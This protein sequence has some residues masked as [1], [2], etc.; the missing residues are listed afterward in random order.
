MNR[1]AHAIVGAAISSAVYVGTCK[2]LGRSVNPGT[3]LLA[4]AL[5]GGAACLH[6]V[7]EP[8]IHPNH[9]GF[10]HSVVLTGAA[11][12][13]VRRYWLQPDG[14]PGQRALWTSVALACLSHPLLDAT[15]PKQLPF[16]R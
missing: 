13:V 3:L 9:R 4:A 16:L 5:G 10:V 12:A 11:L 6:D 1:P 14:D 8:P 15:T 2:W 7:L